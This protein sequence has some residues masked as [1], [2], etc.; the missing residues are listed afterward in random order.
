MALILIADDDALVCEIVRAALEA[1]GHAVGV[2]ENGRVAVKVSSDPTW[3]FSTASCRKWPDL[4]RL[5]RFDFPRPRTE[6]RCSCSPATEVLWTRRSHDV[7][8]QATT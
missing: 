1:R 2:V 4:R 8:A 7:Q 6:R 5:G 3:L